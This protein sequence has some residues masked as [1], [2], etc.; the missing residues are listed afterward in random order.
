MMKRVL[1]IL[2][3]EEHKELTKKKGTMSWHD[4]LMTLLDKKK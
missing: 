1:I 3:D 4:F 2:E